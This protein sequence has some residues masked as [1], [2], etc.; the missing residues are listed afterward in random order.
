[1]GGGEG[2]GRRRYE[3]SPDIYGNFTSET[4]H[5]GLNLGQVAGAVDAGESTP[6]VG[7]LPGYL[8]AVESWLPL[9]CLIDL[10]RK[11]REPT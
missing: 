8:D 4:F 1:M 9:S 2:G 3:Y 5:Q 6:E 10:D 11:N 7:V